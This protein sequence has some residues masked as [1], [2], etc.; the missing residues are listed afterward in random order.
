MS[1]A[2]DSSAVGLSGKRAK[3]VWKS[4]QAARPSSALRVSLPSFGA[5]A[6]PLRSGPLDEG[7]GGVFEDGFCLF[8]STL[9]STSGSE[10]W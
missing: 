7:I 5:M 8:I 9:C 2:E 6:W 3:V 4:F 1:R 10:D